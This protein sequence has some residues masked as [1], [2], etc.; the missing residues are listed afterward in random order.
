MRKIWVVRFN[1]GS[2]IVGPFESEEQAVEWAGKQPFAWKAE[3]RPLMTP[4]ESERER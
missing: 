3:I 2:Q 4:E 1:Y